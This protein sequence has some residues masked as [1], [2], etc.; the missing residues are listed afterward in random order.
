[1]SKE[2]LSNAERTARYRARKRARGYK[3]VTIE[4]NQEAYN[5]LYEYVSTD[6]SETYSKVINMLINKYLKLKTT[7][8][9]F[10]L[11]MLREKQKILK[12]M[13]K[14]QKKIARYKKQK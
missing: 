14:T 6:K 1:M 7:N 3:S 11:K 4:L 13:E 9:E 2:P 8:L 10:E 12:D 5:K